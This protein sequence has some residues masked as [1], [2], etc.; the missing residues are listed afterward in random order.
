MKKK[1]LICDDDEGIIDV[2]R[3]ILEDKGYQV[4]ICND[5]RT[6]YKT[7]EKIKPNILLLDLWMPGLAGDEI[8]RELKNNNT[9]KNI[10]IIIISASKDTEI[11]AK[12]SGA[13]GFICK[14][15]DILEIEDV[16]KKYLS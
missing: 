10:P 14:P 8:T 4:D 6:I 16:V 9:T 15:F 7:I 2:I 13:E 11:V 12:D 5:S 3:I 1:V